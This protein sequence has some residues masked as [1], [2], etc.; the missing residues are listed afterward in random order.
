MTDVSFVVKPWNIHNQ[1]RVM[2]GF[3]IV[4]LFAFLFAIAQAHAAD[5]LLTLD[6]TIFLPGV[7]GRIDH[8][9]ADV[10]G[11]RLFMAAL[12]NN[13]VEVLDLKTGN[14]IQSLSGFAEPQGIVYVPEFDRLF[15]AN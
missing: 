3:Q 13:T 11:Q 2:K 10:A 6:K 14:H 7:E 15:V 1:P 4:T 12:G 9:A 8:I 5:P